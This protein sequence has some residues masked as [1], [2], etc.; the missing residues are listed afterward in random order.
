M[1]TNTKSWEV[2]FEG[3]ILHISGTAIYPNE[4]STAALERLDNSDEQGVVQY[5]VIFNRDKE[6]FCGKHLIG[7]VHHFERN[8]PLSIHHI[9]ILVGGEQVELRIPR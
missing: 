8:L 4:F 2:Q 5:K 6:H 7:A 9:R 1:S 3:E